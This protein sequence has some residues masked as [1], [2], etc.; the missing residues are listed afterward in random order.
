[1]TERNQQERQRFA[2][3]LPFWA[4]GTLNVADRQWVEDYR[5]QYP[6]TQAEIEFLAQLQ[7]SSQS[8]TSKVPES[9]RL[10]RVLAEWQASRPAPSLLSRLFESMRL[11]LRIPA[12]AVATLVV[13]FI[14][15]SVLLVNEMSQ[16]G[17]E[18]TYRGDKP[19]CR[20]TAPRLRVV[21]MPDAK[22]VEI[23]LL[24]RKLEINVQQGPSDIGE[25]W[26]TAPMGR[27]LDEALA[28][29]RVSPLVEEAM[30]V[31]ESRPVSGGGK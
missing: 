27:S 15:Q 22:H 12:T 25:F 28:M 7:A 2:E 20:A 4:N 5:R 24:L 31:H 14:V 16:P 30:M 1:M 26:L 3:L 17:Q 10:K 13:L 18:Q 19:E 23:V 11:P 8:V 9:Q 21:F 29:L 6:E